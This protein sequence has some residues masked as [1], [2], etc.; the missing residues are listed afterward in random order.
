MHHPC[1]AVMRV[2]ASKSAVTT[3]YPFPPTRKILYAARFICLILPFG[4]TVKMC[5]EY[6]STASVLSSCSGNGTFTS[7][8]IHPGASFAHAGVGAINRQNAN[9]PLIN[10]AACAMPLQRQLV[11]RRN[12]T[13]LH[14]DLLFITGLH[15]LEKLSQRAV[16]FRFQHQRI[17]VQIARQVQCSLIVLRGGVVG[18]NSS[19]ILMTRR[20][21]VP[22]PVQR[23][24]DGHVIDARGWKVKIN[25]GHPG[26]V[27]EHVFFGGPK[28]SYR[29]QRPGSRG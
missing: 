14:H 1:M 29:D 16:I 28:K 20:N 25:R 4:C 11:G 10:A 22:F 13:R 7:A 12:A 24:L 9:T 15:R 19:F 26:G 2:S 17:D 3:P 23:K 6:N 5:S 27:F 8:C 18:T 21:T